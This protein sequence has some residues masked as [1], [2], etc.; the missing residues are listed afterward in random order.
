[1]TTTNKIIAGG[2]IAGA[3]ITGAIIADQ[4]TDYAKKSDEPKKEI[5]RQ[6]EVISHTEF[7]RRIDQ[8]N[9]KI[10]EVSKKGIKFKLHNINANNTIIDRLNDS[11]K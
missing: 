3:I 10:L 5:Q 6:K 7:M 1:M 4:T 9:G 11:I 2:A 8:Y